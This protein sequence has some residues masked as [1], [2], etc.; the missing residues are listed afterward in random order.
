MVS[1]PQSTLGLDA[2]S[3]VVSRRLGGMV[4]KVTEIRE[5]SL[6]NVLWRAS[7]SQ[8]QGMSP[9]KNACLAIRCVANH[10]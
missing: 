6:L 5:F 7:L 9:D 10:F 2:R 8:G 3:R 4:L 1:S